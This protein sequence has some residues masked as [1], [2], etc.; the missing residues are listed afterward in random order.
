MS[1]ADYNLEDN[2]KNYIS[3]WRKSEIRTEILKNEE[4]SISGDLVF[5]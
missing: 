4:K 1:T 3:E 5:V 2:T